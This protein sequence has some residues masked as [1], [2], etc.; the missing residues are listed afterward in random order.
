MTT[1]QYTVQIVQFVLYCRM[2]IV[3]QGHCEQWNSCDMAGDSMQ[4]SRHKEIDLLDD[5]SFGSEIHASE[6]NVARWWPTPSHGEKPGRDG[7]EGY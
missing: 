2:H 4:K 5:N 6:I 7:G 3:T 1:R